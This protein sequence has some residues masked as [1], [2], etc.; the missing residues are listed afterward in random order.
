MQKTIL[1]KK[2]TIKLNIADIFFSIGNTA[3]NRYRDYVEDFTVWHD[4]R[5]ATISFT[6]RFG[7]NKVAAARKLSG[8]AEEEKQRAK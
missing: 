8:G 1:K 7:N 2:G 3:N 4:T 6:W 5:V